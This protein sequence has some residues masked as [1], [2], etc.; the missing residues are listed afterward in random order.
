MCELWRND[1][2]ETRGD[3]TGGRWQIFVSVLEISVRISTLLVPYLAPLPP[4]FEE[5]AEDY[6]YSQPN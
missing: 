6:L 3:M 2:L 4:I 1:A 5:A